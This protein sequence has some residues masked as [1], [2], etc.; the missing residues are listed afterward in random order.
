MILRYHMVKCWGR[1]QAVEPATLEIRYEELHRRF[2]PRVISLI[3]ELRGFYVKLGQVLSV[4]EIVPEAYKRELAVLQQG[5]PPK[6]LHEVTAMIEAGLGK[7]VHEVFAWLDA[8]PIGSASIGQV[9]RAT[10]LE[11]G[12]AVVVKVQYPEVRRL[13]D[14][15]FSQ[16]AAACCFWTPQAIGEMA[17]LRTQFMAELDFRR[18]AK[19]MDRVATN[20]RGPFPRIAVPRSHPTLVS[21]NVLVMGEL[22]GGSLLDGLKRMAQAYAEAQGISVE[23]L[24]EQMQEHARSSGDSDAAPGPGRFKLALFNSSIGRITSVPK[25]SYQTALPMINIEK[26]VR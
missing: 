21:E 3:L 15:D 12:K 10:L 11:S 17:E 19:V 22:A 20:L 16:I 9:H 26:T 5:V 24:K 7:K 2:A 4:I 8:T 1:Q 25:L 18:E 14:S 6:P 23:D 13:F